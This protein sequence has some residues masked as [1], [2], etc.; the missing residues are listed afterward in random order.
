V[1]RA[2]PRAAE[3][4]LYCAQ[5][6]RFG[7]ALCAAAL[8]WFSRDS[9]N[10]IVWAYARLPGAEAAMKLLSLLPLLVYPAIALLLDKARPD[11]LLAY[12]LQP[13]LNM[14][15]LPV[16]IAGLLRGTDLWGRTEHTSRVAIADIVD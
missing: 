11:L 12:F 5:A 14:L 16:F 10:I 1:R 2:D 3:A 6:Y 4:A 13:A 15:R 7:A 9:F 8:L